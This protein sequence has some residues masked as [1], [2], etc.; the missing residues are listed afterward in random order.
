M[1]E[2]ALYKVQ[3]C[4]DTHAVS[5]KQAFT[6]SS[7]ARSFLRETPVRLLRDFAYLVQD[8]DI[9]DRS[10][11]AS[12]RNVL[13]TNC[14]QGAFG[15]GSLSP[16]NAE[17]SSLTSLSVWTQS[18][19]TLSSCFHGLTGWLISVWFLFFIFPTSEDFSVSRLGYCYKLWIIIRSRG[20]FFRR[21]VYI[22]E[23]DED[24]DFLTV[25]LYVGQGSGEW[26]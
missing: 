17:R 15:V 22:L 4:L 16:Y 25:R 3:R 9:A 13:G 23:L 7:G 10:F 5:A 12:L 11:Y 19:R 18:R 6:P 1:T 14:L 21:C 20:F 2:T 8:I 26:N 24:K